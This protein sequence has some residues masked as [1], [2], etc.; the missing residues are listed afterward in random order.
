MLRQSS[1][2]DKHNLNTVQ[3]TQKKLDKIREFTNVISAADDIINDN[4]FFKLPS[5][6]CFSDLMND[7]LLTDIAFWNTHLTKQEAK[8]QHELEND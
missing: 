3:V 5:E 4:H 1:N 2:L 7:S 8:L 6:A